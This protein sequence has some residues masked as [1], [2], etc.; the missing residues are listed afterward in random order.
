MDLRNLL[1]ELKNI[2]ANVSISLVHGYPRKGFI[3]EILDDCLVLE[4][5]SGSERRDNIIPFSA[6]STIDIK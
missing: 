6:I 4:K 1:E 5:K 2:K 3:I